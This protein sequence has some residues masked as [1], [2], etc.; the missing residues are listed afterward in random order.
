MPEKEDFILKMGLNTLSTNLTSAVVAD[1]TS[2]YSLVE[3]FF[4]LDY[5]R[6]EKGDRSYS[7]SVSNVYSDL[8]KEKG[9]LFKKVKETQGLQKKNTIGVMG[10]FTLEKGVDSQGNYISYY[11]VWD[12]H[13]SGIFG[14]KEASELLPLG[15]PF[16]IYGKIYY[17]PKTGNRFK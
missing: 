9:E 4:P 15:K 16:E 14:D 17:D 12:L 7:D 3:N 10:R 1:D 8:E 6:L 2:F 13:P 5:E 11:D